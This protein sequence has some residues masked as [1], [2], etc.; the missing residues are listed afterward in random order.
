MI[1]NELSSIANSVWSAT[2]K[3]PPDCPSLFGNHEAEVVIIG[4][5]FTGLTAALHLAEAGIAVILLEA[6]TPG[7]GAS[8]RNGGQINPGLKDDPDAIERHFG[9]T[10]GPRVVKTSGNAADFVANLITKHD[11]DCGF[12]QRGWVQPVHSSIAMATITNR[13]E[14][15]QR[16]NAPLRL[17]SKQE[18]SEILGTD[19]YQGGMID[20]RGGQLH[21]LDYAIGLTSA[22]LKAGAALHGHTRAVSI[23][24]QGAGHLVK[25][26]NGT[27][28][29]RRI[30]ICTNGYTDEIA[31]PVKRSIVPVR[32]IQIA[33][34]PL[35]DTL[36]RSILPLGHSAS[37]SRRLLLYFRFDADG[38]F[39]MGG[40]GDYTE[41]GLKRQFASLKSVTKLIYPQLDGQPWKY[42]WGGFVAMTA[43]H[44]PHLSSPEEGIMSA[45]GYN[46]RGVA[47]ATVMGKILADWASGIAEKDLDFPVTRLRPIPFHCLREPAVTAMIAW[48]RLKDKIG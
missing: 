8:G 30:L 33:T 14:Q 35:S 48:S 29:A 3:I 6:E 44:Y 23:E 18:T 17:L 36:R 25:C 43:D 45:V 10:F 7:W 1:R 27:V 24:R 34:D 37:D 31:S 39:L 38:R 12:S 13:V 5:G 19:A 11:I 47:M 22:A 20:E 40:R 28:K 15:W 42:N 4:G 41:K 26:E 32:S 46:G 2:A 9:P 16:R 21:P